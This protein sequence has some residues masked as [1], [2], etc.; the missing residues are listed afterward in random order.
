[1]TKG[2]NGSS[3]EW[4]YPLQRPSCFEI[5]TEPEGRVRPSPER[6]RGSIRFI[7]PDV[8]IVDSDST[9]QGAVSLGWTR[10]LSSLRRDCGRFRYRSLM[11]KLELEDLQNL[12]QE[13]LDSI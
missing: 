9:I 12:D 6:D 10:A 1:M 8:A 3:D 4:A 2:S 13:A 7:T 11:Y 5:D